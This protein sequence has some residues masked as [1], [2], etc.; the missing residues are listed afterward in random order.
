MFVVSVKQMTDAELKS[1]S[2]GTSRV[3]LM[4]N[5]AESILAFLKEN[6]FP[7]EKKKTVIICGSGNNGGDGAALACLL[8]R[9]GFD[10]ELI[11][12]KNFPDTDT[13]RECLKGFDTGRL[14]LVKAEES[15]AALKDADIILDCVF[16]TGFH[17]ELP[18]SAVKIFKA[19]ERSH[20]V[21][22]SVDIPSGVN[23]TTGVIAENS[24]KPDITLALAAMKTGLLNL[25]CNAF[26]GDIRV[27][28]IGITPHCFENNVDG[29]FAGPDIKRLF[30]ERPRHSNKGTFGKL[31]NIAGSNKYMGAALLSSRAALRSGVGLAELASVERVLTAAAAYIPECVFTELPADGE[32]YISEKAIEI[33]EAAADNYSAVSVGC[34]M[35]NRESTK[36][37]VEFLL[38]NGKTPLILDADGINS[39]SDNINVLKDKSRPV[40]MTP[41]PGEFGRLTGLTAA[42]VQADRIRL[43]RE[44]AEEYGVTLL[45]KGFNTVV[46]PPHG[47]VYIN[48]TGGSA[49][50]KAGCGDVLTGIIGALAAQGVSEAAAAVLGAYLHGEAADLLAKRQAPA[51]VLASEVTEVLTDVIPRGQKSGRILSF[52]KEIIS[53]DPQ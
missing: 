25:P 29:V 1:E 18:D 43:A 41:H 6:F 3:K 39:I 52:E 40:I 8:D 26:C 15:E 7:L 35:G 28:D 33:I 13:A 32:G 34:G 20:A 2:L 50:A 10:T 22:I 47:S 16:G 21:K 9:G 48:T 36:K 49:L 24:F 53:E 4:R 46:A 31:L 42:E 5:A 30:P 45:L 11:L 27:L 19:A 51:S 23:G 12:Q 37:I 14:K 44:F 17:G 38:K